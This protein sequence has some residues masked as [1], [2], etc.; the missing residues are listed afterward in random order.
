MEKKEELEEYVYNLI[1]S[2]YQNEAGVIEKL[3]NIGVE[4]KTAIETYKNVKLK[5]KEIKNI[6]ARKDILY[7][8]LW[9]TGGI[10]LTIADVG[11]IFWGAI[12]FGGFQMFKGI[13]SLEQ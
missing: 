8:M 6:P 7:G 2:E 4:E 1:I 12:V 9:C 11:F 5:M 13:S 10:V 3:V